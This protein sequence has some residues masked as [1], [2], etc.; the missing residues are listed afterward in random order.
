MPNQTVKNGLMD[1]KI[2]LSQMN[3]FLSKLLTK[4]SCNYQPLTFCKIL[5]KFLEPIQS[6]EDVPF[7]GTQRPICSEQN[8]F[9]TNYYY[10]F[11]VAIGPLH[12]A[13]LEKILR[14]DPVMRMHHFWA[15]NGPFALNNFFFGKFLI[16][17]TY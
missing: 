7:S 13:K 1:K 12:C 9:G 4:F 17:S 14:A 3:V 10:Y 16:S 8:F 5:R 11:H 15:Q 6:Y 2:K